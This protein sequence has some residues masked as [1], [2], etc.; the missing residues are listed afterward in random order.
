MVAAALPGPH[1]RIAEIAVVAERID[2]R[3][4]TPCG[5]CRQRLAEFAGPDTLVHR[6]PIRTATARPLRLADL[7]P[8]GFRAGRQTMKENVDRAARDNPGALRPCLRGRHRA[9]LRPRRPCRR[10]R[11]TRCASPMRE[12][13]AFPSRSVIVARQR[14]GRRPSRRRAGDRPLRP[15]ALLRARR[16]GRHAHADRDAARR[17][18]ATR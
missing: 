14:G 8:C 9:R 16:C 2:G 1:R 7:L 4:I 12:L 17:S 13:P 3:L 15:R 5:G 6:L 11:A 10:G 18:A